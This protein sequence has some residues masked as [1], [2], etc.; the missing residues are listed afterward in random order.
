M[1]STNGVQNVKKNKWVEDNH[2]TKGDPSDA[3]HQ[4]DESFILKSKEEVN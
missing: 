1:K 2:V 3:H 4:I